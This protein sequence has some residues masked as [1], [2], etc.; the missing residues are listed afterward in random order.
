M[1]NFGC[2][3]VGS[4]PSAKLLFEVCVSG[5]SNSCFFVSSSFWRAKRTDRLDK[6]NQEN[7]VAFSDWQAQRDGDDD[8][9]MKEVRLILLSDGSQ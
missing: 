4:S 5:L 6:K 1:L 2:T 7:Q 8:R 3:M 9:L